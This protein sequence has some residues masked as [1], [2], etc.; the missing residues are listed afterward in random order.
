MCVQVARLWNVTHG[1]AFWAGWTPEDMCHV[2]R[3]FRASGML[4]IAVVGRSMGDG[5]KSPGKAEAAM[6]ALGFGELRQGFIRTGVKMGGAPCCSP[7]VGEL[8]R[9]A[10]FWC[11]HT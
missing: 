1:F 7:A 6:A 9:S 10:Y 8:G 2:G 3:I 11:P 5:P 4:G